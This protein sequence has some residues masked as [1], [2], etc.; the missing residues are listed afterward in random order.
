MTA[1]EIA[2]SAAQRTI[3]INYATTGSPTL[4]LSSDS[5]DDARTKV[6]GLVSLALEAAEHNTF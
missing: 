6:R 3:L 1:L 5:T 4:D 2:I